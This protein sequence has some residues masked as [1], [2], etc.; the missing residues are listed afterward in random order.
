MKIIV[1]E[2]AVYMVR[3]MFLSH[4]YYYRNS[5][6]KR[7]EWWGLQYA[8]YWHCSCHCQW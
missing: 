6:V 5:G 1:K 2:P 7:T 8:A 4:L 3:A